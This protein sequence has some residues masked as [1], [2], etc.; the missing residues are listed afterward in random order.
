MENATL[1][2]R[3][4][5]AR[6]TFTLAIAVYVSVGFSSDPVSKWDRV[7]SCHCTRPTRRSRLWK[8]ESDRSGSS[9]G[10]TPI[11]VMASSRS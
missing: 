11:S 8:R 5:M 4:G 1:N 10:S 6:V 3:L 9:A 7:S 2:W